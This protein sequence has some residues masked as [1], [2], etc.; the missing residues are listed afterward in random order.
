LISSKLCELDTD[1]Y[2]CSATTYRCCWDDGVNAQ[3]SDR[4]RGPKYLRGH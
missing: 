3:R 1:Q 4:G 2:N